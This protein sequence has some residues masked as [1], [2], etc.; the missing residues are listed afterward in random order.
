M[1]ELIAY[2]AR[3][4]TKR[5]LVGLRE[6]G[7]RLLISDL[8]ADGR[9]A[10]DNQAVTCVCRIDDNGLIDEVCDQHRLDMSE[11]NLRELDA[12]V[13]E[14]AGRTPTRME[15]KPGVVGDSAIARTKGTP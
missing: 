1:G 5:N 11:W 6:L 9:V 7:W 2:A 15:R 8:S 10:G 14:L 13:R 3:T 12:Q 4:G